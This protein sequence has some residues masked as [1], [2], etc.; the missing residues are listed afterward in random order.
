MKHRRFLIICLVIAA[1]LI[2]AVQRSSARSSQEEIR[3]SI[4]SIKD[5]V[6]KRAL[7]C[8]VI[9]GA[10]PESLEY[11]EQNYGLTVNHDDYLIVYSVFAENQ[12]PEVIVRYKRKG[13]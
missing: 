5:A 4:A 2:F 13:K 3:E 7:Q 11:L 9:E 8:Y 10:Y 6:H 1:A 12:P